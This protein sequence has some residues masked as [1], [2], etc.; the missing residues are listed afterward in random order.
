LVFKQ[1]NVHRY[2]AVQLAV[3]KLSKAGG[4][5]ESGYLALAAEALGQGTWVGLCELSSVDP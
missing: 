4:L 5:I 3:F 2:G 1:A